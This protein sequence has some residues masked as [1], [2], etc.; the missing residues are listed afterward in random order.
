MVMISTNFINTILGGYMTLAT[1]IHYGSK[2][3]AGI[4]T[5]G[6]S[7]FITFLTNTKPY[8]V[9]LRR[10]EYGDER[11]PDVKKFLQKISPTT[12]AHKIDKPLFLIQGG[13]DPRVPLS[14]AEQ[15]KEEV[16]KHGTS[17]WYL[18][19]KNEGHGFKKKVNIEIQHLCEAM[20]I[21]QFLK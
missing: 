18:M 13:N 6:I 3:C 11:D 4:S 10:V 5:V 7:N 2:I 12:N 8:R 16:M 19:A 17:V 15:M 9:D 20:F 14:E 21:E 1:M